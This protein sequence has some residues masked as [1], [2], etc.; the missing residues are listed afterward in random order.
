MPEMLLRLSRILISA[1]L[2]F[3]GAPAIAQELSVNDT[4]P[5]DQR[6]PSIARSADGSFVVVWVDSS[7]YAIRGRRF[8]AAG[9]PTSSDLELVWPA[10]AADVAADADGDFVVAWS[11]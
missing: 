8:D 10:L 2:A 3:A 6:G 5:G 11:T 4:P 9:S 7:S 1:G